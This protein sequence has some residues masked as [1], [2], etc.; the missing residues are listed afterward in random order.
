MGALD[1]YI[2]RYFGVQGRPGKDRLLNTTS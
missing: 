1:V 2:L